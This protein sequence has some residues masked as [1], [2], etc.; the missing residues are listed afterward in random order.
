MDQYLEWS[1]NKHLRIFNPPFW[2]IHDMFIDSNNDIRVI[3]L[4][5][6]GNSYIFFGGPSE[7]RGWKRYD[8]QGRLEEE[9]LLD[10]GEL[11]WVVYDDYILYRGILFPPSTEP[12]HWGKIIKSFPFSDSFSEEWIRTVLA[13]LKNYYA[14][15]PED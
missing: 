5:A 2:G 7:A 4:K 9:K 1:R 15:P 14:S 3:C 12:Y 8:S 11:S 13:S 10:S 6:D